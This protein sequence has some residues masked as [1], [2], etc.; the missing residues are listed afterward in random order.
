MLFSRSGG[1]FNGAPWAV[2]DILSHA[3]NCCVGPISGEGLAAINQKSA[4]TNEAGAPTSSRVGC[5]KPQTK[6]LKTNFR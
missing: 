3:S 4:L 1:A 6:Q 2:L 5:Q